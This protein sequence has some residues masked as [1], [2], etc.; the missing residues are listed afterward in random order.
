MKLIIWT[1]GATLITFN[2]M[3]F[4]V[5][6]YIPSPHLVHLEHYITASNEFS[7]KIHLN[8]YWLKREPSNLGQPWPWHVGY[9]I[10]HLE[11]SHS[12]YI[13]AV[14]NIGEKF[15]CLRPVGWLASCWTPWCLA[16]A[17]R[18][19]EHCGQWRGRHASSL[20]DKPLWKH[21]RVWNYM[22]EIE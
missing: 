3:I 9:I 21:R 7:L 5:T 15:V 18:Q 4:F 10:G 8:R 22:I 11:S 20:F 16:S 2:L 14:W 6:L 17:P 1:I 19:Q 12:R 13:T